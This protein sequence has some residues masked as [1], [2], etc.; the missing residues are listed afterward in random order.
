MMSFVTRPPASRARAAPRRL[1]PWHELRS[2][3]VMLARI[4][5]IVALCLVFAAAPARPD[6]G[7]A[8]ER[9]KPAEATGDAWM[10][11][12]VA[13]ALLMDD[14]LIISDM[15]VSAHDGRV[16]LSGVVRDEDDIVA[17]ERIAWRVEGV[18]SVVSSL[19]VRPAL[20]AQ[21]R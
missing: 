12:R 5:L 14:D 9:V 6:P 17:A 4:R 3:K 13:A 10:S 7:G 15:Q 18:H 16:R 11:A 21:G 8:I 1:W 20:S 19:S 2:N